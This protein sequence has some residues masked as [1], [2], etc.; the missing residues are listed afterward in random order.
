[1]PQTNRVA[2]SRIK[3]V[4]HCACTLLHLAG[5][6]HCWW[7][8]AARCFAALHNLADDAGSSPI[9]RRHDG[10]GFGGPLIPCGALV[11]SI[12]SGLHRKRNLKAEPPPIK[13]A[14]SLGYVVQDGGQWFGEYMWAFV[15][16]SGGR[17]FH[18]RPDGPT[19]SLRFTPGTACVPLQLDVST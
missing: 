9:A 17:P 7:P 13:P 3:K 14:V 8:F 5:L 16:D 10:A 1:M 18:S 19:V 12:H 4:I 11:H 15:E 6:P 2:E